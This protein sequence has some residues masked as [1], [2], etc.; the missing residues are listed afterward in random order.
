MLPMPSFGKLL[1]VTACMRGRCADFVASS[2]LNWLAKIIVLAPLFLEVTVLTF[3]WVSMFVVDI[4]VI[5]S[6]YFQVKYL[7][8]LGR[9]C[10]S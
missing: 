2:I 6:R 5:W 3:G 7:S 1:L 4:D 9:L 10:V 8:W